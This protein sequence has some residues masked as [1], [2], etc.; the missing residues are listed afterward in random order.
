MW[1]GVVRSGSGTIAVRVP[2]SLRRPTSGIGPLFRP[3]FRGRE[4]IS[5]SV[6]AGTVVPHTHS[7]CVTDSVGGRS[8]QQGRQDSDGAQ[9]AKA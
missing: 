5:L 7:G 3:P 4:R 9:R 8:G 2:F 1:T 6:L